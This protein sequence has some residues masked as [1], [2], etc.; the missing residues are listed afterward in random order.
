[1][2]TSQII[3]NL[4][5]AKLFLWIRVSILCSTI[6]VTARSHRNTCIWYQFSASNFEMICKLQ[7]V[8]MIQ[9]MTSI[10][11]FN[12]SY[13]AANVFYSLYLNDI[14]RVEL[15]LLVGGVTL[16]LSSAKVLSI[17]F[18]LLSNVLSLCMHTEFASCYHD[19]QPIHIWACEPFIDNKV[20]PQVNYCGRF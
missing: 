11:N 8:T 3:T 14:G 20:S 12:M 5:F 7:Y 17:L 18:R 19:S 9:Y 15:S 1:V 16:W 4:A 10:C 6:K 2:V 13:Y